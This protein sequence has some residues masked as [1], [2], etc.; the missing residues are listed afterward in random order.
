MEGG[1]MLAKRIIPCRDVR[2]GRVVKGINFINIRDFSNDKHKKVD[3]YPF[4]GGPGMVMM[5]P[6]SATTKPAPADT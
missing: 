2:D 1:S 3:D 6:V 4:G 5:E